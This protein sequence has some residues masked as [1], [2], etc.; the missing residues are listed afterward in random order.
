M[1]RLEDKQEDLRDARDDLVGS[2]FRLHTKRTAFQ[3]HRRQTFEKEG[4]AHKLIKQLLFQH[5][6]TLSHEIQ[7]ALKDAAILRDTLADLEAD[8]DDTEEKYNLQEWQYSQAETSLVEELP[9]AVP[10]SLSNALPVPLLEAQKP[11]LGLL[12]SFSSGPVDLWQTVGNPKDIVSAPN[13]LISPIESEGQR[14]GHDY[15]TGNLPKIGVNMPTKQGNSTFSDISSNVAVPVIVPSRLSIENDL[16]DMQINWSYTRK[17]IDAWLFDILSDSKAQWS[18]LK[19]LRPQKNLDDKTWWD[20]VKHTWFSDTSTVPI[21][22]T[23][24]TT[25]SHADASQR[26]STS[27]SKILHTTLMSW[28]SL[29]TSSFAD[30]LLPGDRL[31][32]AMDAEEFPETIEPDDLPDFPARSD[33]DTTPSPSFY[34]TSTDPT[35]ITRKSSSTENGLGVP[36][37]PRY[38]GVPREYDKQNADSR[39]EEQRGKIWRNVSL[40]TPTHMGTITAVPPES[41]RSRFEEEL[42]RLSLYHEVPQLSP[43]PEIYPRTSSPSAVLDSASKSNEEAAQSRPTTYL[44]LTASELTEANEQKSPMHKVEPEDPGITDAFIAINSTVPWNL[45]LLRLTPSIGAKYDVRPSI[46]NIPFVFPSS[47]FHW[48]P[49]PSAPLPS[50]IASSAFE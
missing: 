46:E 4:E 32:D 12:T 15:I 3:K 38:M 42:I 8:L 40:H 47:S 21:A 33:V 13:I 37:E 18:L 36:E 1:R 45:P 17:R 41:P 29:S 10:L 34:H 9:G 48:L 25:I 26:K 27:A 28:S 43:R 50:Y 35:S 16:Q 14:Q 23:G 22:R 30:P 44:P 49:G 2:R 39:L 5:N 11:D 31:V 7:E 24:D 6:I 20:L 19:R